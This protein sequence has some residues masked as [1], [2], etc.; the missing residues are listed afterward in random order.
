[1]RA[2]APTRLPTPPEIA[3]TSN[4]FT[5]GLTAA[6]TVFGV[7]GAVANALSTSSAT[8]IRTGTDETSLLQVPDDD[9]VVNTGT[10]AATANADAISA[11]V[12][13]S[14]G[15]ASVA[16]NQAWDGGTTSRSTANGIAT[17]RGADDIVNS[18]IV[19]ATADANTVSASASV[20]VFG[21][22]GA[23]STAT[24]D[25]RATAIAGGDG[26]DLIE[27]LKAVF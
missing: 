3:T 17:G 9:T 16:A 15:G 6:V 8:A 7:S 23:A 21:V 19:G 26:N 14:F 12:G 11:A 1:M 10:L 4:A 25:A 20:T 13:F 27:N 22:A 24:S 18:G 5:V 2:P